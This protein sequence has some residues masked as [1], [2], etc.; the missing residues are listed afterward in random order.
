MYIYF[1]FYDR[2]RDERYYGLPH[3]TLTIFEIYFVKM[4]EKF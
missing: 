1:D 4:K 3:L 2:N